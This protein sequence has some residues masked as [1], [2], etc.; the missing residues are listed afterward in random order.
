M[1]HA[2]CVPNSITYNILIDALCKK[3]RAREALGLVAKMIQ[4]G[5]CLD[6][7]MYNTKLML[8]RYTDEIS[9]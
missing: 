2:D 7:V 6:I 9:A 1:R 4:D 5:C 3:H 8:T